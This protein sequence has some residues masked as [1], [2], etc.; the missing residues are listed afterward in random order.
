M[1]IWRRTAIVTAALAVCLALLATPAGA[2]IGGQEDTTN[3]YENVGLWQ[4]EYQGEWFGFCSGTLVAENVVLTAAHCMDFFDVPGGLSHED[5]RIT[6]DPT[7]GA[8]STYYYVERIVVHPD[9]FDRPQLMGNSKR[10]GLAPPAEDM[11]LVWLTE[12]P[13]EVEGI[14]PAPIVGAGEL[15]QLDLTSETFTVVGYGIQGFVTGSAMSRGPVVL[16]SGNRNYKAV[17]V[18]N[19]HEAF[20]DRF[21]KITASTCFGDSGGPLFLGETIVAINTWTS[22]MRCVGPS[23]AYRLDSPTAQAFLDLYL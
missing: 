19:E 10:L 7:P 22:S 4:L 3:I 23:Y 15:D 12:S 6:F 20:A 9:W 1:S 21:L 2:V 8:D 17:S 13:T 5:L 11:A 14:Q 16:D 18:I